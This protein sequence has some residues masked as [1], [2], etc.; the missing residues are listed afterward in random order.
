MHQ[1]ALILR[2][3]R[4]P[5]D[6]AD[7]LCGTV[8]SGTTGVQPVIG[9]VMAR[10]SEIVLVRMLLVGK[11]AGLSAPALRGRVRELYV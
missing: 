4:Y 9:Y 5:R 7:I 8:M 10:R 2:S 11:L 1:V 6:P 3:P